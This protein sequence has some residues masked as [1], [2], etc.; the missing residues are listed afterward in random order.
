MVLAN[1]LKE[2]LGA[3]GS[4]SGLCRELGLNRTQFNRYLAGEAYPRP[5]VL[6]LICRHFG[7]DARIMLEPLSD[8]RAGMLSDADRAILRIL[9]PEGNKP[10]DHFLFPDG[11]YQCWRRSFL[12]PGSYVSSMWRVRSIDQVKVVEGWDHYNYPMRS[13]TRRYARKVPWKGVIV[14]GLD[15]ICLYS[16][17]DDEDTLVLTFLEFGVPS[18]SRYIRGIAMLTRRQISGAE[19]LS[20][21]LAQRFVGTKAELLRAARG[22]GVL[23]GE[24][25]PPAV[26]NALDALTLA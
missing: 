19:R 11:Y 15:G 8:L 5:D 24:D 9:L 16:R 2:L 20:P 12:Q 26:R 1:N 4:I 22:T 3:A 7:V 6:Q 23:R 21:L 17:T 14:Q 25:L 13:G 18:S 10:F